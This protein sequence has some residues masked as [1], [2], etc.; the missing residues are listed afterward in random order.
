MATMSAFDLSGKVALVT[1]AGRGIGREISLTLARAGADVVLVS[2][3]MQPLVAV[4]VEI[5]KLGRK[6]LALQ[7][8]VSV[9]RQV[10]DTVGKALAALERI[11]VLVNCAGIA[12]HSPAEDTSDDDWLRVLDVNLSGTFWCCRSVGRHMLAR[13]LGAIV[14]VAS[15]SG[16]VAM[17]PQS[18]ASYNASK[19]GVVQLTK[20][21]AS[22]WASRGVRV[23]SVSSGY[24]STELTLAGSHEHPTWSR[25]WLELTPMQRMGT[26]T[27]VANAVWY[28]ASD[29]AAY[30]T[31]TDL[32]V[33]GG[34]TAR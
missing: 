19:A 5:A 28:L 17:W 32:V 14:N 15:I 13:G 7:A 24:I 18:Q 10:D 9:S 29:A 12:D 31:G 25:T 1:G 4:E 34:Y 20:S 6:S 22:E 11:D 16:S 2:R 8:D 21:L 3:S 33:D 27:D 26:P 23:N 30:A